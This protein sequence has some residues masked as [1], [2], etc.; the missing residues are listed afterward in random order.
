MIYDGVLRFV[1]RKPILEYIKQFWML[2]MLYSYFLVINDIYPV[3]MA[4]DK[5]V[6]YSLK[7]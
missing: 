2:K 3:T 1:K 6:Q 4:T 5:Q 7:N